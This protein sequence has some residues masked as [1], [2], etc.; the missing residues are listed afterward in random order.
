MNFYQAVHQL[1]QPQQ[2][3]LAIQLMG[4]SLPIWQRFANRSDVQLDYLISPFHGHGSV[5]KNIVS[6]AMRCFEAWAFGQHPAAQIEAQVQSL[7]EQYEYHNMGI[8]DYELRLARNPQLVFHAA[9]NLLV[10]VQESQ[11]KSS[12]SLYVA[13]NKG[14]DALIHEQTSSWA[15]I[16]A[17][18]EAVA[19]GANP[20]LL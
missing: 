20:S 3:M 15:D 4:K 1:K 13:I 18:I 11:N 5:D 7:V 10:F 12:D 19:N 14:V 16:F 2:C 6:E 9:Y 17:M 8:D